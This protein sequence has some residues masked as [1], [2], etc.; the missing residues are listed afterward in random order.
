[1]HN[2]KLLTIVEEF[3]D[4]CHNLKNCQYKVLVLTDYSNL[5]LFMDT[6]SLSSC[7]IRWTQT[8]SLYHFRINYRKAKAN[9]ATD[10]LSYYP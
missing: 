9:G 10:T 2:A 1:M 8:L 5:Y 6:K 3:K 7:Q 4:R